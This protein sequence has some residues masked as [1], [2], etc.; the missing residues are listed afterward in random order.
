[1]QALDEI[2]IDT[3]RELRARDEPVWLDLRDPDDEGLARVADLLGLHELALED[4]REFGQRPK[5]DRYDD[6]LLLVLFGLAVADDGTPQPVEVHVHVVRGCVLTISR[7]P[8]AELERVRS[9]LRHDPDRS[10]TDLLYRVVDAVVDSLT[11]GLELVAAEVDAFEQT[12]FDHPRARDRDRMA[13]LRRTLN[14][15]RRTLVIQRQ[16]FPRVV[17]HLT[18]VAD[19]A[20]TM[21]TYLA[22]VGDHLG[23]AL[24]EVEADRETLQGMLDTYSNEV[25]ER[26]TIV[27]TV[28]LPLTALTGF[29]GMNFTWMIDHLGAAWAFFGL[30]V[31]GLLVSCLVIIGWLRRTGLL[32]PSI[33]RGTGQ[34]S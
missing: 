16:V 15:L 26:L 21:R 28:F 24:D 19:D 31:G 33:S 27:A 23:Q 11:D 20:E 17:E 1:M 4:S 29:F 22:D 30:G 12:I 34:R 7:V 6:Q 32:A 9:S 13:V 25:Q 5:V 18:A 8:P 14:G 3:L 2:D 10:G